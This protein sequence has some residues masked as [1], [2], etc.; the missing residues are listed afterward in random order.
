MNILVIGGTRYFGKHLVSD[1]LRQSNNVTI[2][3]RGLTRDCY[4]A[5]VSRICVDRTDCN[6]IARKLSGHSYDIVY[7]NIAYSSNDVKLL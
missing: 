1:L 3:T 5:G 6:D 4:G 7:D 2:T